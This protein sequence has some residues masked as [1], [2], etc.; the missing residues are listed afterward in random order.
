MLHAA[1]HIPSAYR[2][3][4]LRR[5]CAGWCGESRESRIKPLQHNVIPGLCGGHGLGAPDEGRGAG[6]G[7]LEIQKHRCCLPGAATEPDASASGAWQADDAPMKLRNFVFFS[8][9]FNILWQLQTEISRTLWLIYS[10]FS[11]LF[12]APAYRVHSL[13]SGPRPTI[14]M[15]MA[16]ERR[17]QKQLQEARTR[18]QLGI[19][20]TMSQTSLHHHV[21]K[22]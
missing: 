18:R 10:C 5:S 21:A 1:V 3:R 8:L 16:L 7:R 6:G 17:F 11:L 20:S 9:K 4:C 13:Q 12:C 14:A 2:V 19:G 15:R 22:C